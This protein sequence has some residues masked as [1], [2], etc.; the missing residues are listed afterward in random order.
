MKTMQRLEEKD[1]KNPNE[2]EALGKKTDSKT[3]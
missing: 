3:T 2:T 1:E